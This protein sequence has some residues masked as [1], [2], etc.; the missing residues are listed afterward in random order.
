MNKEKNIQS[1]SFKRPDLIS[2]NQMRS[3]HILHDRFARNFSSSISAYLRSVIEVSLESVEQVSY[4]E[5][6]NGAADPTCYAAIV[7]KP[8]DGMAVV[9]LAPQL[10]FPMIDRLLGGAGQ[11]LQA[12]RPM[13]EIE[14]SIIQK[15]MKLLV[16]NLKESWRPVYEIDFG[17]G[18]METHPQMLQVVPPGEMV[19]HFRF[20]V[21]IRQTIARMRLAF[22]TLMLAPI[23]HVFDQEIH[24]RRKPS[25][26]GP[27][28]RLDHVPVRV[29][30][31]TAE[32]QF[33]IQ[34]LLSLQVGDTLVLDQRQEWP[35]Q[36]K[37][38]GRDKLQ[39]VP[40]P[41]SSKKSFVVSGHT[42]PVRE[43][44]INGS[45]S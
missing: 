44:A 26:E 21:R 35:V 28:L 6:L 14:Q 3:L 12:V 16:D 27:V 8:L 43:E 24:T 23:V 32:T 18:A 2:R 15:V 22:P 13:T 37:V 11:C 42:R 9:E 33:P 19:V 5:F 25:Q 36:L 17:T 1:F 4:G 40:K 20:Q 7:P 41:N 45:I 34:A 39:A 29:S 10:V 30:I 31:E 38:C